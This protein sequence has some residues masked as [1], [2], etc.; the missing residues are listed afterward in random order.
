MKLAEGASLVPE[1]CCL[2]AAPPLGDAVS[3]RLLR[4]RL[5]RWVCLHL[6]E[7]AGLYWDDLRAS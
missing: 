2:S 6:E 1:T 4:R 5:G 3:A 7:A